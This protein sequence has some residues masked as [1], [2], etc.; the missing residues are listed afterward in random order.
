MYFLGRVYG[1]ADATVHPRDLEPND[2]TPAH[3]AALDLSGHPI[4]DEHDTTRRVGRV[5]RSFTSPYDHTKFVLGRIEAEH[6]LLRDEVRSGAKRELSLQHFWHA[7]FSD[8]GTE[9]QTRIPLEVSLAKQGNRP[10]CDII[11]HFE[12]SMSATPPSA[13]ATPAAAAPVGS[14]LPPV[15]AAAAPHDALSA[16]Q[17]DENKI[18]ESLK[19]ENIPID[20][21]Y[22]HIARMATQLRELQSTVGSLASQTQNQEALARA[23]FEAEAR[24]YLALQES[25]GYT[26]TP[27]FRN[28]TMD[29]DGRTPG[30]LQTVLA[31]NVRFARSVKQQNAEMM[32]ELKVLREHH[33]AR[34]AEKKGGGVGAY[35]TQLGG[36]R[37][38]PG[39]ASYSKNGPSG[40]FANSVYQTT[41]DA[42]VASPAFRR[43]FKSQLEE[44]PAAAASLSPED[45]RKT[46]T[47]QM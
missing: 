30:S 35:L 39:T 37:H 2:F 33:A 11:Y 1:A 3:A 10:N 46:L 43:G 20:E 31:N 23:Q 14:P 8:D 15:A 41:V 16:D 32:A 22:G 4:Y 5:L 12:R 18:L 25:M 34:R 7:G 17:Y 13:V 6:S 45:F 19:A 36:A 42:A 27:E 28:A 44:P 47:G 40:L 26:V 29:M 38:T 21:A 24:E 9:T